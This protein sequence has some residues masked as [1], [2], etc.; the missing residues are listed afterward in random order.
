[1]GSGTLRDFFYSRC[2][3]SSK[4]IIGTRVSE[5]Q[6]LLPGYIRAFNV[7][8]GSWNPDFPHLPQPGE[9]GHEPMAGNAY[10]SSGGAKRWAG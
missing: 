6:M 10:Q 8:S 1:M 2:H 9:F 5:M 7:L 4:L 3:L